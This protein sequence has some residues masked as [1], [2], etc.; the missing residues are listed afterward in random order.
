MIFITD[1]FA[2]SDESNYTDGQYRSIALFAINE[3]NFQEFQSNVNIILDEYNIRI[4]SFKW[5][6]IKNNNKTNALVDI[7][8]KLFNLMEN[9]K[10]RIEIMTWNIKDSRHD[11]PGRVDTLNLSYMYDKLIKDFANRYLNDD[12]CLYLFPDQNSA[13]NWKELEEILF[14]QDIYIKT[15]NEEFD[16]ILLSKKIK[17]MESSTEN[18][19]LIQMADIF[20][21]IA[22]SSFK[23][24]DSYERWLEPQ[25]QRLFETPQK[26]TNRQKY[27][28]KIYK[29]IDEWAK[30]NKLKISLKSTRG[31]ISHNPN[32]PLNFWLYKPQHKND[33]APTRFDNKQ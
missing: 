9:N 32:A 16:A 11:I 20:A 24:Y 7:L 15:Y 28:F 25:Q 21:G 14:N 4:K 23:D 22:K 31:F 17:I 27:R 19:P 30:E 5:K 29:L 12:D 13:I 18:D 10:A 1:Y 8:K 26:F 6:E 2:F 3:D 33:K